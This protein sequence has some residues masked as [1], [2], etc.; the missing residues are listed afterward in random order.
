MDVKQ[1]ITNT[2]KIKSSKIDKNDKII[3]TMPYNEKG[4]PYC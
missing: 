4:V 2:I 1:I 3:D